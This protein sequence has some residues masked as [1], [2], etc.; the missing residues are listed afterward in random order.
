MS[1]YLQLSLSMSHR[2]RLKVRAVRHLSR[3][4]D[5]LLVGCHVGIGGVDQGVVAVKELCQGLS[6]Y[7]RVGMY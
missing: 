7:T 4:G 1:A 6:D 3:H 5:L 2:H